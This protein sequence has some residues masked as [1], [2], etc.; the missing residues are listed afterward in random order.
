MAWS[1]NSRH[2]YLLIVKEP[3]TEHSSMHTLN[4]GTPSTGGWTVAD[5]QRFWRAFR[6]WCAV[7]LDGGDATQLTAIRED[8]SYDL[9]PSR[10]VS[11][12]M[13]LICP[14][15]LANTPAGHSMMYFYIKGM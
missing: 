8:G 4:A 5:L 15:D 3:D 12:K 13:R 7:N 14:A 2:L 10:A 9:V 6:P 1:K 11:D